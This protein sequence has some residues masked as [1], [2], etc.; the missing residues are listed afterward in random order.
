MDDASEEL[1]SGATSGSARQP[2]RA[3]SKDELK[4]AGK[5]AV[6][7]R[8][9]WRRTV[10][11][12]AKT[13]LWHRGQGGITIQPHP[14]TG[15]SAKAAANFTK[16]EK[17]IGFVDPQRVKKEDWAAHCEKLG[18]PHDAGIEHD[19]HVYYDGAMPPLGS[20]LVGESGSLTWQSPLSPGQK[21]ERPPQ[22]VSDFYFLDHSCVPMLKLRR[23][24]INQA[25][26]DE[27]VF[28]HPAEYSSALS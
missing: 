13:T 8:C 11:T 12:R 27:M 3:R 22:S 19:S 5:M 18:W 23:S 20:F 7:T 9:P 1:F 28:C 10:G 25:V 24:L 6:G 14:A 2:Q 21:A 16:G 4:V 17:V 26:G 15:W